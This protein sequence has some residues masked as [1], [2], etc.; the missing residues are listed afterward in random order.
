MMISLIVSVFN[1]EQY[2]PRC[3]ESLLSQTGD[4]EIILVDDGSTDSSSQLCNRYAIAYPHLV[5]VVHKEN[6][7]LFSAR[8][9]GMDM[10]R[11]E[12]VT[13][14][15]PD[16][17]VEKE[18]VS[19]LLEL[20]KQYHPDLLCVGYYVDTDTQSKSANRNQGCQ[21]MDNIQAQKALLMHPCI[22]GFAWN[23]LYHLNIIRS[24]GL[25]F[26]D[27]AGKTE[28][29]DFTFR[30][31]NYCKEIVFSPEDKL[32]HYYQHSGAATHS[33][34]TRRD[35]ESIRTYEKMIECSKDK[36]M[37]CAAEEEICNWSINLIW[38]YQNSYLQDQEIWRQ[39]RRYLKKYLRK[40]C[41]SKRYSIGR[42]MQ[43]ILAYCSPKLYVRLK[44]QI[45]HRI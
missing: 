32:Y 14:P 8:N 2:L 42:K 13:F 35:I 41:T 29:L 37:I 36:E 3:M 20:Q 23:K 17:W 28:D 22:R 16:D 25:K 39:L 45:N 38:N 12:L 30:Y 5:R 34:F 44:N 21:K 1:M 33:T 19:R 7:G 15:D 27:A 26:S 4:Y 11:G 40:Y 10:A 6:G 43:A 24:N 9:V 18:Y 31:L